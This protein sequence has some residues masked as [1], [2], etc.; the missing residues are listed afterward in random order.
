MTFRPKNETG[1]NRVPSMPSSGSFPQSAS[2]LAG[3]G[4]SGQ[5]TDQIDFL[6]D[7]IAEAVK[8]RLLAQGVPLPSEKS[9]PNPLNPPKPVHTQV[10]RTGQ[11]GETP[12]RTGNIQKDLAQKID[13]TLLKPDTTAEE[14]E[15]IC[16]E[17][18]SYTHLTLPTIYSV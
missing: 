12:I 7:Q 3:S 6:V 1:K 8:G 9:V 4:A 16:T 18:V 13:H 2:H 10:D 17:A 11:V 5:M 14:I 15:R